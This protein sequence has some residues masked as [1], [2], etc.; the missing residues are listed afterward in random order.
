MAKL[1]LR[2]RA[3]RQKPQ[4]RLS[5]T[6]GDHEL[7]GRVAWVTGA[8]GTLGAAIGEALA[9]GG[10]IVGLSGRNPA[11]LETLAARLEATYDSP[12]LVLPMN[13]ASRA[14]VDAAAASLITQRQRI[15]ILVNCVAVPIFGDFL[16]LA[17]DDWEVVI[18][19]KYLGYVRTLRAV[20][21]QMVQQKFGRIVNIS[22]RGGRQPMAAHLPGSSVNAAIN[23]LTKGLADIYGKHNIRINAV[24]PGPIDSPR[25]SKVSTVNKVLDREGRGGQAMAS[26]A[27]PIPRLG[28]PREIAEAV[29][30][31]VSERS[32][33]VTGT[34]HAVDG[35]GT[36]AI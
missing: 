24:L 14:Q 9:A 4:P 27:T 25:L 29:C 8:S 22:G 12:A 7:E 32:S 26:A 20:L 33:Y 35:G 30:Y 11:P 2:N 6:R 15:D 18:Q 31:L 1:R 10:A 19:S 28:K 17:D 16:Q 36:A 3:A 23:L 21:P 13:M 5:A 34:L